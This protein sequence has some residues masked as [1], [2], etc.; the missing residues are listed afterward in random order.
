MDSEKG[1]LQTIVDMIM[2]GKKT[3][4]LRTPGPMDPRVGDNTMV[5][6]AAEEARKRAVERGQI[7]SPLDPGAAAILRKKR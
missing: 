5:R 1:I 2:G 7:A 6:A 3:E 4:P